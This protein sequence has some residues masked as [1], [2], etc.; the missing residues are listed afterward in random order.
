MRLFVV[1][2][3]NHRAGRLVGGIQNDDL[4][5]GVKLHPSKIGWTCEESNWEK[6]SITIRKLIFDAKEFRRA[7]RI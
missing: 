4:L 1:G 7:L 5:P 2:L 6:R 3:Y